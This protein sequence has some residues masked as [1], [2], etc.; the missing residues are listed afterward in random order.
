MKN[1]EFDNAL[2]RAAEDLAAARQSAADDYLKAVV[3]AAEA[4]E[5]ALRRADDNHL[6]A[7]DKA[8]AAFDAARNDEIAAIVEAA[9]N[10]AST[11]AGAS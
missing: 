4:R 8:T 7:V 9:N 5:D 1:D 6:S 3:K 2:R 11:M 10:A